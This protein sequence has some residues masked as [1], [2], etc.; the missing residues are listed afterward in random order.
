MRIEGGGGAG[1]YS[2]SSSQAIFTV[3]S[4]SIESQYVMSYAQKGVPIGGS[5]R[6]LII[7]SL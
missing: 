6:E 4:D 7:T 5:N 2:F 1:V 3:I